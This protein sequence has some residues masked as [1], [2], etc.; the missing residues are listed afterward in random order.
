MNVDADGTLIESDD[1][2]V[3]RRTNPQDNTGDWASRNGNLQTTEL[4]SV[5]WDANAQVVIG[6]AQDTGTPEQGARD[7]VRWQS[8]TEADGAVVAVDDTSSPGVSTRFSSIQFLGLLS[9]HYFNA[10]NEPLGDDTPRFQVVEGDLNLRRQFYT[11]LVVNRVNGNRLIVG[12]A[13]SV[14]ESADHGDS[15]VE[16]GPGIVVN[17]FGNGAIA[18]GAAGN[19][20][21]L[22]VGS[23]DRVFVRTGPHPADLEQSLAYSGGPSSIGGGTVVGIA[24]DPNNP[25]TAFVADTFRVYRTDDA[26]G[27][28]TPITGNPSTRG[29]LAALAP[30]SLRT[31]ASSTG[32]T[33]QSVVVGTDVGVFSASGPNFTTWS[34]LGQGFPRVP[35][36]QLDARGQILLAGTLGRGAW[37][38]RLP[39]PPP[40]APA[41]QGRGDEKKF[42]RQ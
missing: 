17:D 30:G 11:P 1:G 31:I 28:W 26:G 33:P 39:T 15:L 5:A 12:A 25:R 4:H 35:V 9:R 27:N 3:Y 36:Y 6:G 22:Y 10:R 16:V 7:A 8:V 40:A 21:I 14:Y 19:E 38:L 29:S 23:R 18:Y 42:P 2:G 24:V 34:V 41:G 37:T 13:N 32:T 20:D